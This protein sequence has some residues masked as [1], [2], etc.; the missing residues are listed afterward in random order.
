MQCAC[1]IL[2]FVA[3]P[4]LQNFLPC[5][6]MSDFQIKEVLEHKICVLIFST[7]FSET[8]LI[9]K[10]MSETRSKM[11]IGLHIR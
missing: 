10:E 7:T 1:T 6:I 2:S 5:L 8:F 3:C 4:T 9:Q 11:N